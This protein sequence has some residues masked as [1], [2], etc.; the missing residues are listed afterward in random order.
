MGWG[1]RRHFGIAQH[2]QPVLG[3][4]ESDVKAARVV[5]EAD[6]LPL[7]GA[8]ARE[9]DVILLPS[10]HHEGGSAVGIRLEGVAWGAATWKASTDATSTSMY[11]AWRRVPQRCM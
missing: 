2:D 4:R 11:R 7:I 8:N 1:G 3:T 9:D 5:E 10:L 6:A